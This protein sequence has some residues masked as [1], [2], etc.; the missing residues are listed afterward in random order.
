MWLQKKEGKKRKRVR[1]TGTGWS[2]RVLS[3]T[4]CRLSK[5]KNSSGHRQGETKTRLCS[6]TFWK[7]VCTLWPARPWGKLARPSPR[8]LQV[9]TVLCVF[10]SRMR[11]ESW[12]NLCPVPFSPDWSSPSKKKKKKKKKIDNLS[13]NNYVTTSLPLV[14]GN[15]TASLWLKDQIRKTILFN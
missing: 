2:D 3:C 15:R 7:W 13:T 8:R 6:L 12:N 10:V 11:K 4:T 14:V 9:T 5:M 1:G